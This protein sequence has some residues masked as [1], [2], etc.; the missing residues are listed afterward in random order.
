MGSSVL[1]ISPFSDRIYRGHLCGPT[2]IHHQHQAA[3]VVPS[4]SP[5]PAMHTDQMRQ[6]DFIA[7][8][9][10]DNSQQSTDPDFFN[11][12][13]FQSTQN[14]PEPLPTSNEQQTFA[15]QNNGNSNLLWEQQ[16]KI[17]QLQQL[18]QLQQQ[19]FQQQVRH[20]APF[21]LIFTHE[22]S[23]DGNTEWHP[24][25]CTG[26]PGAQPQPDRPPTTSPPA[27]A[28]PANSE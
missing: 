11:G 6:K 25:G 2:S 5:I 19:I 22:G 10:Q 27:P 28:R 16:V 3:V 17:Q 20:P 14:I 15:L 23:V 18:H 24:K 21:N 1:N 4:V 7:S 13:S 26:R 12:Q 9:F 8:L